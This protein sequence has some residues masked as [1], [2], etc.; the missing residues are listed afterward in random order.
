[1]LIIFPYE[2]DAPIYHWPFATVGLIIFNT[3]I[4]FMTS[5][6]VLPEEQYD[7]VQQTLWL[8]FGV[9]HLGAWYP[10]QW[11]TANYYHF[12][13]FHLLG[14]MFVLWG[15]GIIV[16]G[17]LGWWKY[18]LIYNLIGIV[19][20]AILQT[21]MI[22]AP[23]VGAAGAS[24]CIFGLLAIAMIWAPANEMSVF[25]LFFYRFFTMEVTVYSFVTFCL[26]LEVFFGILHVMFSASQ[27]DEHGIIVFI[28]SATLH[29]LGATAGLGV[30]LVMLKKGWVDCE[31]WDVFS[32]W[33]GRNRLSKEQLAEEALNSEE[34]KRKLAAARETM[35]TQFLNYLKADEPA[36]ALAVHRRGKLQF[37]DWR[38]AEPEHVQLIQALRKGQLWDDTVLSMVEYLHLYTER[39]SLVRLALAQ[40]LVEQLNRPVQG[41][42]V[43]ARLDP[44]QLPAPQQQK[45][46]ALRKRAQVEAEENP[47]EATVD[48]W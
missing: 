7:L 37:A 31:N 47:F 45:L 46:A 2:T 3:A 39:A 9:W 30:G 5:A 38:L 21:L 32:V 22:F 25:V 4:F 10:W 14:N 27:F 44:K 1:M 19:S 28:S 36:A 34:G 16:E 43:L 17:K 20:C 35:H 23:E 12:D 6:M 41:M 11:I 40:L 29:L 42:K 33:Q 13:F 24:I 18:L 26:F 48:D 8:Q 15:V